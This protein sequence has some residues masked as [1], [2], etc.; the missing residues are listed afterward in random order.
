MLAR[1]LINVDGDFLENLMVLESL[2][3]GGPATLAFLLVIL[4]DLSP[5]QRP[6]T[7]MPGQGFD[8]TTPAKGQRIES[9]SGVLLGK[10]GK[11]VLRNHGNTG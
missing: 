10:S 3:C 2:S 8:R 5:P 6:N 4:L 9:M 1:S 7:G 11:T